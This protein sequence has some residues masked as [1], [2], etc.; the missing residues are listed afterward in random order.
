MWEPVV[1]Y[2]FTNSFVN[3]A[4]FEPENMKWELRGT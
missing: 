1:V 3:S 2:L 4:A